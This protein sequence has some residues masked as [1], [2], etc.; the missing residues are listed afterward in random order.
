[1]FDHVPDIVIS[2]QDREKSSDG[3]SVTDML[4]QLYHTRQIARS[5]VSLSEG[6]EYYYRPAL[7]FWLVR[8]S[9]AAERSL[10]QRYPSRQ[11]LYEVFSLESS[12]IMRCLT[13]VVLQALDK[14]GHI[15]EVVM[16]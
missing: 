15:E 6:V 11:T 3:S 10:T 4:T 9:T 7:I 12:C 16:V 13:D 5:S 8:F 2:A 1:M 14:R